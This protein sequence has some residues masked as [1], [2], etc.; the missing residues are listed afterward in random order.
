M[1][2]KTALQVGISLYSNP[3]GGS[4]PYCYRHVKLTDGWANP[5]EWLPLSFDLVQLKTQ[6]KIKM[7]WYTGDRWDGYRFKETDEVLQWKRED[8]E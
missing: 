2:S 8:D 6:D 3:R 1:K 7:G 4:L 5:K